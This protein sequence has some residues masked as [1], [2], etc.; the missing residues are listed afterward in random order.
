M[1]AD[2]LVCDLDGP[3]GRARLSTLVYT[4]GE[5]FQREMECVF[6]RGW[7]Y[8]AHETQ[9]REPGDYVTTRIGRE[10]VVVTRD[11]DG[12]L[13]VLRNRCLHRGVPVCT[14]P[15]GNAN[16]FRCP[17]HGWTYRNDGALVGI[18]FPKGYG[19]LADE[20][21][22]ER[23][24]EAAAVDS[25]AG[26]VF[27]RLDGPER[28]SL[29]EHLGGAAAYL[30]RFQEGTPG[31][32][33]LLDEVPY[34]YRYRGNWKLQVENTVDA[35]H[36]S[37]THRSFYE[38]MARRTGGDANPYRSDDGPATT[39]D[40]GNGHGLFELGKSRTRGR[41]SDQARGDSY[42]DRARTSPGGEQLVETLRARVGD[43][44]A[45]RLLEPESDFNLAVF[46]NLMVVQAQVRVVLPVAPDW[47][48]VEAYA[49]AVADAPQEVNEL[50]RRIVERF[51]GPCG[52]GSPDDLEIF[53]R[54][55]SALSDRAPQ[56]LLIGRGLQR[57]EAVDGGR[58]ARGSDEGPI[59]SFYRRWTAEMRS[60]PA[61]RAGARR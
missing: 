28:E 56:Q 6:E 49:T 54:F 20:L 17:Y 58:R 47:T 51:W 23:L 27:A 53:E 15:R 33:L 30:T 31:H 26:F 10:A 8:V 13:H 25:W 29:T 3:G 32:R 38:V 48:E 34:R 45:L 24:E 57:E 40:L 2:D 22:R 41:R 43:E 46:P 18:T 60:S 37:V 42:F 19:T 61:A 4:D 50:R 7:V 44:A 55:H 9:L 35:Y 11:E 52:F 14:A 5:L 36:P 39:L 21:R 59:R 1:T 12:G 16:Y